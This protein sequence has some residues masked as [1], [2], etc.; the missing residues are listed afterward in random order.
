[1]AKCSNFY[2]KKSFFSQKLIFEKPNFLLADLR[3]KQIFFA[4]SGVFQKHFLSLY[5]YKNQSI[6][7]ALNS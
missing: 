7:D 1:M 4:R 6:T 2:P 3:L 5:H